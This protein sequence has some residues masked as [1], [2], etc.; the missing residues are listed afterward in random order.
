MNIRQLT[1]F[2]A[3]VEG[4]SIVKASQAVHVSQ[5]SISVQVKALEDDLGVRLFERSHDGLRVTPEG[6]ELARHAR[7]V[8]AALEAATESVRGLRSTPKGPVGVGIPGSM[9]G[10]LTR[11]LVDRVVT[12]FPS[13]QL[14]V[15]GGL[16]GHTR[17]WILDGRMDFGL[18]YDEE[19]EPG[20]RLE[21]LF[22]ERLYLA[23]ARSHPFAR[24]KRS[25]MIAMKELAQLRFVL[26]GRDYAVR[27]ASERAA[28]LASVRLSIAVEVDAIDQMV[29]RVA[30]TDCASIVSV[31]ALRSSVDAKKIVAFPIASL[32]RKVSLA[33]ATH[34]PLPVAAREVRIVFLKVLA[35]KLNEAWWAP[36]ILTR[37]PIQSVSRS[38]VSS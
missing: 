4:G 2:L 30:T 25:G 32:I 6:A 23:V 15:V 21:P 37:M 31:A 29:Q 20:L 28:Q 19:Q 33:H 13:V 7:G 17:N 11:P 14:R 26:P 35:E 1:Y 18:V 3:V 9:A 38:I 34:R 22:T 24:R 36:A 8:M 16:S 12:Q 10:V 27:A 5:P